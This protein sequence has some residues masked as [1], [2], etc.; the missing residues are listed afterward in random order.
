M[1][2]AG[3]N[4]PVRIEQISQ[5]SQLGTVLLNLSA[6]ELDQLLVGS[7]V[8]VTLHLPAIDSVKV[9]ADSLYYERFLYVIINGMLKEVEVEI[10]GHQ[11]IEAQSFALVRHPFLQTGQQILSSKLNNVSA[12]LQ[13]EVIQSEQA[14]K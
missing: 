13:V 7:S 12:G 4:Y 11:Q 2:I 5:Q 8:D 6:P 10:V 1:L 14:K 9:P 3:Q